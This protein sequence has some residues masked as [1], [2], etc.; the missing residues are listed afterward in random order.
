MPE[1]QA[2]IRAQ[3]PPERCDRTVGTSGGYFAGALR[4]P[5]APRGRAGGHLEW[6]IPGKHSAPNKVFERRREAGELP[7]GGDSPR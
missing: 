3:S 2:T 4:A 6:Q 7:V 1:D 5:G